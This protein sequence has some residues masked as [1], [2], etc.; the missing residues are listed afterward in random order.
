LETTMERIV[1]G[2]C[3]AHGAK[4]EFSYS[5]EFAATINTVNEV[6]IAADVARQTFG[7]ARVNA[8][9][10]PIMASEDFGFMLQHKPGCYLL[11]GNGGVGPGGCGLHNPNYDFND[12]IL[13]TGAEFWVQLV[14]SELGNSG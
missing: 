7:E 11:L 12:E 14:Q 6:E 2:I 4:Y 5:R 3:A 10:Q 8:Q 13:T 1:S 9:C